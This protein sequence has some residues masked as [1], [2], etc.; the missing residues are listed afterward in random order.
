MELLGVD[1]EAAVQILATPLVLLTKRRRR[2][3]R[4]GIDDLAAANE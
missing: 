1:S 2:T 4:T 3:M